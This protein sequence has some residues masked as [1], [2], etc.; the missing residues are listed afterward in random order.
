MQ[1]ERDIH[2]NIRHHRLWLFLP[3]HEP[4]NH[5][6]LIANRCSYRTQATRALRGANGCPLVVFQIEC[7][8]RILDRQWAFAGSQAHERID[9]RLAFNLHR[10][11]C[12]VGDRN[13][14]RLQNLLRVRLPQGGCYG[15]N[16]NTWLV[17][18]CYKIPRLRSGIEWESSLSIERRFPLASRE[19][20]AEEFV[21]GFSDGDSNSFSK[22]V[23]KEEV[24]PHSHGGEDLSP[25]RT[26]YKR[27]GLAGLL[28]G[29]ALLLAACPP[30]ERI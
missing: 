7:I 22:P 10:H 21:Q 19:F 1:G 23:F 5:E 9:Q 29:A 26:L 18:R 14:E 13:R 16:P 8:R 20:P 12:V 27:I 25:T 2:R 28:I 30:R 15:H 11:D 24:R 6:N 3:R 4:A 17:H